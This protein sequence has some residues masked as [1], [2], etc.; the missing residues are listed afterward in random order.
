MHAVR[1]LLA[2]VQVHSDVI[3]DGTETEV[4]LDEVVVGDVVVLRAGDVIPADARLLSADDL[5]V[6]E[7]ALTGE[8]YPVHKKVGIVDATAVASERRNSVFLGTH[9]NSGAAT[10]LVAATGPQSQLGRIGTALNRTEPPTTF[11]RGLRSFGY[12]LMRVGGVL[13]VAVFGVNLVFHRPVLDSLLF[14]LAL[15]I[16]I[17]PQLLPAVVTLTL[18]RGAREMA[19]ERVIVKRLSSIE[20]FGSI[21][22]LC[23]DKTGTLT[24]G[25]VR[26]E[27]ALD[28]EGLPSPAVATMAWRN[29]YHQDGFTNPIDQAILASAAAPADQG[30]K[31]AEL[32]YDFTRKRLSVAMQVASETILVTKGAFASVRSVCSTARNSDQTDVPIGEMAADLDELFEGLCAHG[33]RVLGVAVRTLRPDTSEFSIDDEHDMTL[34]GL[35]TFADPPKPGAHRDSRPACCRRHH[36]EDDHR[37]QSVRGATRRRRD[38]VSLRTCSDGRR[39][40]AARR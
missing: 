21:D 9:V 19:R 33:L 36:R 3:R 16:G 20:D 1:S 11:E 5:H 14:S 4:I 12:L 25:A 17:T 27:A 10:A 31:L 29:A 26:M 13:V 18:S 23:V 32:P 28:L 24:L 34:I 8:S 40:P 2:S 39:H 38:R 22:V 35:V 15:A 7:S 30:T 6:D 37:R